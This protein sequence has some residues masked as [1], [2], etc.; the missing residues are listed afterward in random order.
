MDDR[1]HAVRDLLR[2]MAPAASIPYIRSFQLPEEEELALIEIDARGKSVQQVA[3]ARN[4]SPETVKRRRQKA[5]RKLARGRKEDA[6]EEVHCPAAVTAGPHDLQT[7]T[8]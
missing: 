2:S 4:L 6:H 3:Q 5:L 1:T 8:L 7:L